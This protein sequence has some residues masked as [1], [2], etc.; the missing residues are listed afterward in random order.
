MVN[1]NMDK[2][3]KFSGKS[4]NQFIRE[5][6]LWRKKFEHHLTYKQALD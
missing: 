3:V 4:Y 6:Y 1:N 2:L 5:P